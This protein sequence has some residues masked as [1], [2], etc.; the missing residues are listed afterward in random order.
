MFE[1]IENILISYSTRLPLEVFAF[2]ASMVEEVVAPIPSPV[3][4]IVTG[5]LAS[6]QSKG[7]L[8][9]AILTLIGATGKLIGACFVY[10]VADKLED[11]FSGVI[12]KFF[13]VKHSDIE[14]FG[15]KFNGSKRDYLVMFIARALPII[16]SSLVSIGSGLLKIPLKI[17][18]VSTFLGTIVRDF[19]YI[20]F[21]YAGAEVLG[22]FI[23]K[24]ESIESFIQIVAILFIFSFLFYLRIKKSNK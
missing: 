21:G 10:Y 11:I 5:S 17:Y 6:I 23:K 20:Y 12:E 22:D 13:G 19:I 14:S 7:W 18:L 24:S 3:V 15:K 9:L 2:F 8:G 4:M 1:S 16:P